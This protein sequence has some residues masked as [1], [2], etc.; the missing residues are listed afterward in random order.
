MKRLLFTA[1]IVIVARM[2][3]AQPLSSAWYTV[4]E[5]LPSN[6]VKS[7]AVDSSGFLWAGTDAGL[8]RFDGQLFESFNDALPSLKVKAL[9]N[10]SGYGMLVLTDL[11]LSQIRTDGLRPDISLLIPG[12]PDQEPGKLHFAKTLFQGS[13]G[14]IWM[15]E[16]DAILRWDGKSLTRYPIS[17]RFYND[18]FSRSFTFFEDEDGNLLTLSWSGYLF[19][20]DGQQFVNIPFDT[21]EPVKRAYSAVRRP[22]N[23]VWFGAK[24]G[25]FEIDL[26]RVAVPGWKPALIADVPS[27]HAM[28][29]DGDSVVWAGTITEGLFRIRQTDQRVSAEKMTGISDVIIND[30]RLSDEGHIWVAQDEGVH[31]FYR[32]LF[33]PLS[34]ARPGKTIRAVRKVSS[35]GFLIVSFDEIRLYTQLKQHP[36]GIRLHTDQ[37]DMFD[38]VY[39]REDLWISYRDAELVRIG[40]N[41]RQSVLP[42]VLQSR[43]T[44]MT[45]DREGSVWGYDERNRF[46]IRITQD[47][48]VDRFGPT[49]G[50]VSPVNT[51]RPQPDGTVLIGGTGPGT[52]LYR[53]SPENRT[54]NNISGPVQ[55]GSGSVL[56]VYDV[57]AFGEDSLV[58]ATN[59]G[60]FRGNER[61]YSRL[62]P[63]EPSDLLVVRALDTTRNGDLLA[64]SER[65]LHVWSGGEWI[66]F[67]TAS[68][69]PAI[70]VLNQGMICDE[71]NHVIVLSTRQAVMAPLGGNLKQ[72]PRPVVTRIE[73]I[74]DEDGSYRSGESLELYFA[75]PV[76]PWVPVVYQ[77]KQA[78]SP[79]GWQPVKSPG[80]LVFSN[81]QP[82]TMTILIRAQRPGSLWSQPASVSVVLKSVWYQ[83]P[84][85]VGV[86]IT[87]GLTILIGLLLLYHRFR[88]RTIHL[89]QAHLEEMVSQRTAEL[90]KHS[91]EISRK[92][93]ELLKAHR[94]KS[95][96]LAISSHELKNP[97]TAVIGYADIL[98]K[99]ATSPSEMNRLN[100]I[101][102]A[103]SRM[104]RVVNGLL[105]S[106]AIDSGNRKLVFSEFSLTE[107]VQ[108]IISQHGIAREKKNQSVALTTPGPVQLMADRQALEEVV[109]NLLSN[110]IK[111]APRDS[112]IRVCI[113]HSEEEVSLSVSDEG[114]GIPDQVRSRLFQRFE[115]L[116]SVPTGGEFSSG[117]GLS[118]A[119]DLVVLHGG[120]IEVRSEPGKGTTFDVY[121]P[122]NRTR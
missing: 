27:A 74:P 81:P 63:A 94:M 1:L 53:Y 48:K 38:A 86:M 11:G 5:N 75:T 113:S 102:L 104:L 116:G 67:N 25:V 79:Q 73:G 28:A 45:T 22:G 34:E 46:L 18:S 101:I 60:L 12:S 62:F 108:S 49:E 111:Y 23:K 8:A 13:D 30:I 9:L 39:S 4:I 61:G 24:A 64:A 99:S 78:G 44:F 80:Y 6:F 95:D 55:T 51:I 16:S 93:E 35:G 36:E 29:A 40:R 112:E 87:A 70:P 122:V 119:H 83:S 47:L 105:E 77:M 92:N 109:D 42:A 52:L 59:H 19:R 91:K 121:L 33:R 21:G 10:A 37:R 110:A 114:P 32:K 115:K 120:R 31:L 26:S 100:E 82:G 2:A 66:S 117:L 50:I 17:N 41:G 71:D 15:G 43:L 3:L 88:L 68:G 96:L 103:A 20:F 118:I 69:L 97:L 56:E 54:I 76:Y 57:M 107:C 85:A 58:I 14:V 106:E 7:V 90:D 98:K 84:M 72:T 89:R 65:G